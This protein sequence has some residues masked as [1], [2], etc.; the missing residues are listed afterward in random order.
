MQFEWWHWLVA[1]LALILSELVVPTFVLIWFG[2][3]AILVALVVAL[4]SIGLTAQLVVWLLASMAMTVLW[5]QVFRSD[6][7]KTRIG[8]ADSTVIGEVG[9][10]AKQVV[11]FGKGEVRF[12]KPVLG[13]DCWPCIADEAIEIGERVRVVN[14]EG[15]L[16]KV[17]KTKGEHDGP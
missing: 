17:A 5:F 2:L 3:G 1:G 11:P 14:V 9:V 8:T 7:H 15:S 16:L 13:T 6:H 12:Q 4:V 10:L